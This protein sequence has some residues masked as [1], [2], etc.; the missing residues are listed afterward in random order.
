MH[1]TLYTAWPLFLGLVLM[2]LSNGLQ[3]TLLGVRASLEDFPVISIGFVMSLYFV[4]FLAGSRIIPKLIKNVGHIRVF[5]A[6][7]ALASTTVLLHGLF[8]NVIM[9]AFIRILTGFAFAGLFT[10][11]E[12]WL[13]QLATNQNR[14]KIMALYLVLLYA[15][16]AGGQFLMNVGDP[17]DMTLFVLV[18]ILV[19]FS[20]IPVALS[21]R[22]APKF[23]APAPIS[24]GKLFRTSPLGI[25]GVMGSGFC[26]ACFF[27]IASVYA[28]QEGLSV[29]TL[30]YFMVAFIVGGICFQFPIGYLSDRYDR[31]KVLIITTGLASLMSL[32]AFGVSVS[33]ASFLPII[34]F[35]MG[36]FA[37][38][39]Y[40]LSTAHTNDQITQEQV[41]ATSASLLFLNSIAAFMGPLTITV[42]M[43]LFGAAAFFPTFAAMYALLACFGLYRTYMRPSVPGAMRSEFVGLPDRHSPI[44]MMIAEDTPQIL[45]DMDIAA[46]DALKKTGT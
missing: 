3:G 36:G 14:G 35:F 10:V 8:P 33:S 39:I 20:M 38:V 43:K 11:I 16:V 1:K 4:G 7:A 29:A 2:M 18:S 30:S 27:S 25:V 5:S 9:W 44:V 45:K 37:L 17:K 13:N 26:N 19:S 21:S 34:V 46:N 32:C 6:L 23:D 42:L 24:L 31:R 15:G 22:P 40:A 41:V 12:S 28:A